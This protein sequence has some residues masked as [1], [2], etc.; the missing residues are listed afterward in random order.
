M[1][2]T[3]TTS[4]TRKIYRFPIP[5]SRLPIPDSRFPTPDSRLPTPDSPL[6]IPDSRFPI[7]DSRF[8]TLLLDDTNPQSGEEKPPNDR[9]R[10]P[11][12]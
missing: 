8:F 4:T 10:S 5:D 1:K 6:P 11:F 7:P 3:N 2:I 9:Q 12:G